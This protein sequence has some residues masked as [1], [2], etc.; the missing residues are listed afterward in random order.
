MI[1]KPYGTHPWVSFD[2]V[3]NLEHHVYS[4]L[5]GGL[6]GSIQ[7]L[8]VEIFRWF[9]GGVK[10]DLYIAGQCEMSCVGKTF[11]RPPPPKQERKMLKQPAIIF[12]LLLN[13]PEPRLLQIETKMALTVATRGLCLLLVA[14]FFGFT[15][16]FRDFPDLGM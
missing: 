2:D 3:K 1:R 12:R 6:R 9:L 10:G 14:Q 16:Q 13:L 5:Y 4:M 8:I 11:S 15:L 7:F